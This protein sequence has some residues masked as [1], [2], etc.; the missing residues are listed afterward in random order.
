M[1]QEWLQRA[2]SKQKVSINE[3]ES[4]IENLDGEWLKTVRRQDLK[5]CNVC[6]QKKEV[7]MQ[8]F[9]VMFKWI[10]K[11]YSYL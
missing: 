11:N 5:S 6:F 2:V 3:I 4:V 10:S 7:S 1:M 9:Y 8:S